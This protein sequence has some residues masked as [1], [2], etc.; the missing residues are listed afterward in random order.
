MSIDGRRI[1]VW[2]VSEGQASAPAPVSS[3]Q[4]AS[5]FQILPPS[6]V[7]GS[8]VQTTTAGPSAENMNTPSM[9]FARRNV[10]SPGRGLGNWSRNVEGRVHRDLDSD[11]SSK[12]LQIGVGHGIG[13]SRTICSRAVPSAWM[14]AGTCTR[15]E[16]WLARSGPCSYRRCIHRRC[17]LAQFE[18]ILGQLASPSGRGGG[19]LR[20]A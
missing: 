19:S 17:A 8:L 20:G 11:S 16:T 6:P 2:A 7:L 12:R 13:C 1:G 18:Q 9:P 15:A 3:R 4:S 14:T 5:H 10:R